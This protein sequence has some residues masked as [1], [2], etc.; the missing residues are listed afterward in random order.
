MYV[1]EHARIY[2]H[3]YIFVGAHVRIRICLY[4]CI[5]IYIYIYIY[6]YA[7]QHIYI[8]TLTCIYVNIYTYLHMNYPILCGRR[9]LPCRLYF[10]KAHGN[11]GYTQAVVILCTDAPTLP[12]DGPCHAMYNMLSSIDLGSHSRVVQL[13]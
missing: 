6:V 10:H 12:S 4:V 5:F 3:I 2:V 11:W 8:Y 13:I 7:C 9:M 1:Y